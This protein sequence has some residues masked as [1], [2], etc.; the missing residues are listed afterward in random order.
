MSNIEELTFDL[1]KQLVEYIIDNWKPKELIKIPYALFKTFEPI[2]RTFFKTLKGSN[3]YYFRCNLKPEIK[4]GEFILKFLLNIAKNFNIELH[5]LNIQNNIVSTH[6]IVDLKPLIDIADKIYDVFKL[7]FKTIVVLVQGGTNILSDIKLGAKAVSFIIKHLLHHEF[8]NFGH[9]LDYIYIAADFID[10]P[11][12]RLDLQIKDADTDEILLGY[13]PVTNSTTYTSENGFF[14]GDLESQFALIHLSHFPLNVS[15]INTHLDSLNAPIYL[16]QSLSFGMLNLTNSYFV[17]SYVQSNSSF[18]S[19]M[20][21]TGEDG[22]TFNQLKVSIMEQGYSWVKINITDR[23]NNLVPDTQL[24]VFF[25]D[26]KLNSTIVE[27]S[28]GIFNISVALDYI[29]EDLLVIVE[30]TGYFSN[31][32]D[33][34]LGSLEPLEDTSPF[35]PSF[36]ML[37]IFLSLI[38]ISMLLII[39]RN[40]T[41][42]KK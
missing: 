26:M 16:N 6:T 20:N 33:I 5:R 30:K 11:I 23:S 22:L 25:Q 34:L 37:L 28:E 10:P 31:S 21:F 36:S 13:D 4:K 1:V 19:I 12:A 14:R 40:K 15:V 27:L 7:L 24:G 3:Q 35:I 2:F 39:I 42:Q 29:N 18:F 32:V 41:L 17:F 38:G 9:P 8:Q